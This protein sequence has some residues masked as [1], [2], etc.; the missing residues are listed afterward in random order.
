VKREVQGLILLLVAG[1]LLKISFTGSYVRYVKPGLLPLL[2]VSGGVLTAVAVVALW[3][4]LRA[5]TR[6]VGAETGHVH[7]GSGAGWFLVV[8]ALLLVAF[9]P[10]A[11]G[12]FQASRN[13]TALP[14]PGTSE[15]GP[16]AE[17]DPVR[18]SVLDYAARAVYDEGRTLV[19][20][21]VTLSGFVIAGPDGTPYLARMV[22]S[23]CAADAR[24]VKVGLTGQVPGDLQ[25][26]QWVEVDGAYTG[27]T[28][29]DP[30]ND[31]PIPYLVVEAVRTVAAPASG[32]ES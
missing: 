14:R 10:P 25:P 19:G 21:R 8:P 4:A 23:C 12:S 3:P 27:R 17:G 5:A 11:L 20:R 18:V 32:Y 29:R 28:D 6:R 7:A 15:F 1:T 24:P 13:G 30:V 26:D 16:L 31:E 9:A 22:V 2:I